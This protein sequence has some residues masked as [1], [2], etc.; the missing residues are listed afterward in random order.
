MEKKLRVVKIDSMERVLAKY[1]NSAP[2]RLS[3]RYSSNYHIGLHPNQISIP[4]SCIV[5]R[6][7]NIYKSLMIFCLYLIDCLLLWHQ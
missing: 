4:L 5:I 6:W 3:N 7:V 2:L 1:S